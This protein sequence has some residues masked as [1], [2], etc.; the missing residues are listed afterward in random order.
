VSGPTCGALQGQ[1]YGNF[2]SDPPPPPKKKTGCCDAGGNSG[3]SLVL[4]GLIAMCLRKRR[5]PNL[6]RAVR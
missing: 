6:A 1:V 5:S 3:G 4:T 2:G